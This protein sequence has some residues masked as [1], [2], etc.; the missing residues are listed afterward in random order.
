[1]LKLG[2]DAIS[3]QGRR[4]VNRLSGP[5]N[6]LI[7]ALRGL[8]Q[9]W[10]ADESKKSPHGNVEPAKDEKQDEQEKEGRSIICT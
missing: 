8:T 5:S 6:P 9:R 7:T 4:P 3:E 10:R 1:M 2:V